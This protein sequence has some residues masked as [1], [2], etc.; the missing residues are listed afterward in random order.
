MRLILTTDAVGGVW[1][2]A[3]TLADRLADQFNAH[4]MLAVCGRPPSAGQLGE[5]NLGSRPKGGL[6]QVEQLDVPLEWEAAPYREYDSARRQLLDLSLRWR[7]HLVHAN[8]HY[9]GEIGTSGMPVV[10]VSHSDLCSW[11][12]AVLG[13]EIPIVDQAYMHRLRTGLATASAVVAPSML[14]AQ[15]L[16]RWY[17]FNGVVRLIANGVSPHPDLLPA[18]R[19]IDAIMVG[20]LWDKAKNLP[21]FASLAEGLPDRFCVAIG[22][23]VGPDGPVTTGPSRHVQFLGALP[24]G[25]VR[26]HLARAR[27][28]VSPAYYDPFGLAAVEAALAG[29]SLV[30]SDILSYREIWGDAALY[31]EP[32]DPQSARRQVETILGDEAGRTALAK[33]VGARARALY[34]AERMA[35]TY[36]GLYQ[37]LT[38]RHGLA[39]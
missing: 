11:R 33:Q 19:P 36:M 4:I 28:F 5:I 31:F 6:V 2:Y 16:S 26:N 12:A 30:L 32:H 21:C 1:Q 10:V 8:E 39:T 38:H 29:C 15:G 13:E 20:R 17:A 23:T 25:E 24:R 18:V 7:A 22:E 14:V 34:S 35:D 9:L 3:T 37:R 27:V